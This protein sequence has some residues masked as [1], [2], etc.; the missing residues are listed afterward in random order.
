MQQ[1]LLTAGD[2][3]HE[4]NSRGPADAGL[5]VSRRAML[6]AAEDV[7][8]SYAALL[9]AIDRLEEAVEQET[10][11]LRSRTPVDLKEF[12]TRKTH[13]HL[14]LSRA[15]RGLE[16]GV[17]EPMVRDRLSTLRAKLETN[18]AVLA[19]H[20]EAVREISTIVADAIRESES[21]G[22]YS[23]SIGRA[24]GQRP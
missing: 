16:G 8:S 2:D 13:G 14:E 10:A 18:R 11:A 5:T 24:G 22:T 1:A 15:M 17:I 20:L 6:E 12:H 4:R 9:R 3:T 19:M 21:D 7:H 23:S